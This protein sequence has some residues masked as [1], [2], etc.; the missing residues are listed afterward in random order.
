MGEDI[1]DIKA[2]RW[3]CNFPIS[4]WQRNDI[5]ALQIHHFLKPFLH[6]AVMN[7]EEHIRRREMHLN[8]CLHHRKVHMV[9]T[10]HLIRTHLIYILHHPIS[11][12]IEVNVYIPRSSHIRVGIKQS[13]TLTFQYA[14]TKSYLLKLFTHLGWIYKQPYVLLSYLLR[15]SHPLQQQSCVRSQFLWQLLN[16]MKQHSYQ[17]LL[18]GDGVQRIPVSILHR[19]WDFRNSPDAK[20]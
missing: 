12:T 19:S 18:L 9:I 7:R 16:T 4:I 8:C 6:P 14:V 10:H 17:C 13:V 11:A 2:R 5:R 20:L 15:H 3:H 1:Y